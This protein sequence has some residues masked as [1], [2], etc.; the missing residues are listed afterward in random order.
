MSKK[1]IIKGTM[2][3]IHQSTGTR[4]V[5]C[6]GAKAYAKYIKAQFGVDEKIEWCGVSIELTKVDEYAIVIG[7]RKY[8]DVY[9][10]K[11]LL[12]HELSHTVSQLMEYYNFKCDEFRSYTLQWLYQEIM[13]LLDA[14]LLK[15]A[16]K[17]ED[18]AH[19][20]QKSKNKKNHT[21]N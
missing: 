12:I 5:F 21:S 4:I 20:A 2:D 14:R 9:A 8:K 16:V 1:N 11:G 18:K 10:L 7:I 15:D 6:Y 19:K 3:F 13:P 17:R